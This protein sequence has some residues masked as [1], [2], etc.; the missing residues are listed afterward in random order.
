MNEASI[1]LSGTLIPGSRESI[2]S[3]WMGNGHLAAADVDGQFQ[4]ASAEEV[5]DFIDRELRGI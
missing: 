2:Y 1:G 3:K 5:L 4:N